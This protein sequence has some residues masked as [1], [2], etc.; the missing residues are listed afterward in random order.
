MFLFFKI[1]VN[2]LLRKTF[3]GNPNEVFLL[4]D[5]IFLKRKLAFIA[6]AVRGELDRELERDEIA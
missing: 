1:M 6:E 5:I 2:F 3:L 4:A